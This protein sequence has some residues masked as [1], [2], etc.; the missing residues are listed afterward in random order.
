M[1]YD[2]PLLARALLRIALPGDLRAAITGD[3][4]EGFRRIAQTPLELAAARRWYWNQT[5]RSLNPTLRLAAHWPTLR[6]SPR[7]I[8][9]VPGD[10]MKDLLNDVRY[11]WRTFRKS[12]GFTLVVVMTL[13]IGIGANTAIFSVVDGILLRP[14]PYPEPGQLV[15]VWSDYTSRDGPLREWMGYPNFHDLKAEPNLFADISLYLDW[16]PTLTGHGEP[17]SVFGAQ[18]TPGM[19]SNVLGVEPALGRSFSPDEGVPGAQLVVLLSH[20]FWTTVLAQD[21][22]V[23]GNTLVFDDEPH[24]VVGVMPADFHPPFL[25][26]A[27]AWRPLQQS[28]AQHQGGRAS[29]LFRA[30]GRLDSGA[31]LEIARART[32]ALGERLEREYPESNTGVGYALFPLR[33]DVVAQA[34]S[35]LW[36]LLAAVGFVLLIACVN[37][38]NLLLARGTARGGELAIRSALGAG[39]RRIVRQLMTE[40]GLLALAGGGMGVALALWGTD[41]L[42]SLAPAGTPRIDEVTVDSR[43]LTFAGAVTLAAGYLFGVVPALKSSRPDRHATLKEGGRGA[44]SG[45]RKRGIRSALVV[46]QVALALVLLVGAGLLIRSFQQ[47]N[48]VDLGFE[49][50]NLL[51]AT[52]SLPA[53]RYPDRDARYIFFTELEERLRA[54]PGVEHVGS[55]NSLPLGGNNGDTDFRIDGEPEPEPGQQIVWVRRATPGYLEA[56]GISVL[57][58][59]TITRNDDAQAPPV[60][61]INETLANRYFQNRDP[62]GTRISLGTVWRE[63][64]GVAK[65]VKNFGVQRESRNALYLPY[66]QAPTGFLS[67]VLRTSVEPNSLMPV[68]RRE[69]AAADPNL[70]LAQL[71]TMNAVVRASLATEQFLTRLLSLFAG[72][73]LLLAAVGLYGVVSYSVTRRMREM[74]VRVALG[75]GGAAIGKLVVRGSLALVGIGAAMGIAGAYGLTRL[76]K[77]LLFGVSATDPLTFAGVTVVLATVAIAASL[78][79]AMRAARVDPVSVLNSE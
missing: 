74:G 69:I 31:S 78:F 75:A 41:L 42:V 10:V 61:I 13:A 40:S 51:T 46:T 8:R 63:I 47:L 20:R 64:V 59:R 23:V 73:A 44:D 17:Q 15:N 65:D 57:R 55:T 25:A 52:I 45:A 16:G 77:G 67:L 6:R 37:V 62:I 39:R 79:P 50:E 33:D 14:L 38:A 72:I 21:P 24:T 3:L 60:V 70:A 54:V 1:R 29:A 4:E 7:R 36:V 34:R 66:A 35:G 12:P 49:P 32:D 53:V 48:A 68:V 28:M 71:S 76:M 11:G 58:G 19:F 30:V 26:L 22:A 56:A 27:D 18:I 5:L 43:I 9:I 2:P